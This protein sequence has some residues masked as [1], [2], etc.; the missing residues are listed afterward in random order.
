[1]S[2]NITNFLKYNK[3]KKL[4]IKVYLISAYY[5]FCILTIPMKNIET[6]MGKKGAESP[7]YES[8]DNYAVAKRL[9]GHVNRITEHTPWESMCFVRALTLKKLL[10]DKGI[11]STIY[12]GVKKNENKMSAHA[13]LRSGSVYL[14]GGNGDGYT[15]VERFKN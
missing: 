1:M 13:W 5:R 9:A 4:T 2:I 7:S 12:L 3:Q 6:K 14:T 15:I 10:K 8:L 11:T